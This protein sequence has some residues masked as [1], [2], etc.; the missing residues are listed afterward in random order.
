MRSILAQKLWPHVTRM[1]PI[2][3]FEILFNYTQ[4]LSTAW[5]NVSCE[6]FPPS[7]LIEIAQWGNITSKQFPGFCLSMLQKPIRLL[8]F[9]DHNLPS[10]SLHQ[11]LHNE[12]TLMWH[13]VHPDDIICPTKL[14]LL[15]QSIDE[16][17]LWENFYAWNI[18]L[19]FIVG[20]SVETWNRTVA[21]EERDV[22]LCQQKVSE[23]IDNLEET[24]WHEERSKWKTL[25][26]KFSI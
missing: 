18:A 7:Q 11:V 20:L 10:S 1:W 21:S 13:F 24:E 4:W 19:P 9:F 2:V 12:I 26:T 14:V 6:D 16:F 22:G 5:K 3:S 23:I 15:Q 17:Q 25:G 8:C